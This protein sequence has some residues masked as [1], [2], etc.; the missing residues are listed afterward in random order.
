MG[1]G[2]ATQRSEGARSRTEAPDLERRIATLRG[3]PTLGAPRAHG[4]YWDTPDTAKATHPN[5][6]ADGLRRDLR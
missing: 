1:R 6:R 3:A 2:G 4:H 5:V